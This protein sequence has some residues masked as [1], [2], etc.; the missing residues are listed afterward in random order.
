MCWELRDG[1]TGTSHVAIQLKKDWRLYGSVKC[2]GQSHPRSLCNSQK[3]GSI[4]GPALQIEML[5]I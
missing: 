5:N 1:V 2:Y 3:A 4:V